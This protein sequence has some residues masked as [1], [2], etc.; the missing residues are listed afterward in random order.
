MPPSGK[1][2]ENVPNVNVW[3]VVPART[4]GGPLRSL[5]VARSMRAYY[6]ES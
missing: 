1:L 6:Q 5:V 3:F 2:N 4:A